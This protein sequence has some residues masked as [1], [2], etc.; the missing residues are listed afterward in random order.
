VTTGGVWQAQRRPELLRLFE[1]H[2]YGGMPDPLPETH[3][4]LFDEDPNALRGQALRRQFSLRFG[5]GEQVSTMDLLLYLPHAIQQPVPVFLGAIG[6]CDERFALVIS[7]NS[8][9]GGAA[10]SRRCYGETVATINRAFP[11]WYELLGQPGV[12][13]NQRPPVDEPLTEGRIGDHI[14]TGGHDVTSWGWHRWMDFSDRNL[15]C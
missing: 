2:V 6:A 3:S 5:A 10:L 12:G 9:C 11:H 14:R 8:G 13:S 15:G 4:E 7:N 1:E